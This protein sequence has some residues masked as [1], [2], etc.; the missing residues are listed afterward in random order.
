[1]LRKDKCC[2]LDFKGIDINE[3]PVYTFFL[4]NVYKV[5]LMRE[6]EE[7]ARIAWFN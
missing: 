5:I 1:M 4:V 7:G 3:I 6:K 2:Y